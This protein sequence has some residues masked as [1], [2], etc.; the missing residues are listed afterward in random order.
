MYSFR[1][2]DYVN[3]PYII[4]QQN[5]MV[6]INVALEIDLTGQVCAD[7]LGT[8]FFSGIGGQLDFN[9]GAARSRGGKAII[10]LASTA[11]SGKKSRIVSQ[12]SPGAGVVT[13]RGD[14]HYVVTEYGVAYLH[15]KSVSERAMALISISHP[16]Y[17]AQL[18]KDAV[19]Y[20]YLRAEMSDVAGRIHVR[21]PEFKAA[22]VLPDGTLVNFR[23]ILPT[24]EGGIKDLFY[25]LSQ[26]TVYYRFMSRSKVLTVK[27]AQNFTY[28]DHR[29]EV[30]LVGTLR[31][32]EGD[33]IIAV[34][35]Y[36]LDPKTNRAEVAFT[37]RDNWQDKGIGTFLLKQLIQ[38][39]R[40]NGIQ[41]FTAEVLRDNKAM[42]AVFHKSPTKVK[43]Q[44]MAE[45]YH[46]ELEFSEQ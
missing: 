15:G 22:Y 43:S 37:V 35:R 25:A 30:C 6:A 26:E 39:A 33:V 4:G 16:D 24:D 31:E 3:D 14:V 20:K 13:T 8:K 2:T 41:G 11:L 28:V 10:A 42:Q 19:E 1:P 7:S 34:G 17:R 45:S 32:A 18:L 21:P 27:Q 9:R 23:N 5:Q 44:L 12:L 40:R 38:T 46:F 36:Y 29:T